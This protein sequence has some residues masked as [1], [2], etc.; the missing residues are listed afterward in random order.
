MEKRARRL[1][2]Q[3]AALLVLLWIAA[4]LVHNT[5][6]NLEA[7]LLCDLTRGVMARAAGTATRVVVNDRVDVAVAAAAS[8]VHLRADAPAVQAIRDLLGGTR[9]IGRS[10]HSAAEAAQHSDADYLLFGTV[11]E[12]MMLVGALIVIGSG[13]YILHRETV[14]RRGLASATVVRALMWR[15]RGGRPIR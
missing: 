13:L 6:A 1:A 5:A 2:Y 11:P 3:A 14:L 12:P 7:R 10:V 9:L 8:G 15:R 4:Y